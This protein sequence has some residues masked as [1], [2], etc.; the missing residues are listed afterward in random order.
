MRLSPMKPD[1]SPNHPSSSRNIFISP[2]LLAFLFATLFFLSGADMFFTTHILG[3]NVRWGQILLLPM[4]WP[5]LEKLWIDNQRGSQEGKRR[6]WF[7]LYWLPFFIVYG[8]AALHSTSPLLT[9]IKW[10]WGLFNIGLAALV[11]LNP[12]QD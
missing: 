4:A 1:F 9:G 12:R 10:G 5:A 3:F 6:F 11:C 2:S 8:I 7:L